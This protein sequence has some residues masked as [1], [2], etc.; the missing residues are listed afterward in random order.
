[1][2]RGGEALADDLTSSKRQNCKDLFTNPVLDWKGMI[3]YINSVFAFL[4][5][6]GAA[7]AAGRRRR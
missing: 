3:Q 1:M 5:T 4:V 7:D 6:H 2:H